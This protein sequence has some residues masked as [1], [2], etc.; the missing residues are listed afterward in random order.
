VKSLYFDILV[1]YAEGSSYEATILH[2]SALMLQDDYNNK[3]KEKAISL[4]QKQKN[5]VWDDK[6][7]DGAIFQ[8]QHTFT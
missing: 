1:Q 3:N 2:C 6:K 5:K 7:R 4:F 8:R